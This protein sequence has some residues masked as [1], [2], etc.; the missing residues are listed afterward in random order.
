MEKIN[1]A[2][3]TFFYVGY[4]PVAPG[5]W[6]SFFTGLII[7]FAFK[8]LSI[9]LYLFLL[10][11]FF[12]LGSLG[13][14]SITKRYEVEDPRWIVLD[15]VIG[16]MI[17]LLPLYYNVVFNYKVFVVA[18]FLFRFFDILKPFPVSW[19]DR[20]I[21][22]GWGVMLDDVLAGI[23]SAIILYLVRGYLL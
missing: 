22:N 9:F 20:N 1:R 7:F 2:F 8:H 21:K 6:A 3:L 12:I 10:L 15:E 14:D 13:A 5:T 17:S 23:Y 4:F 18:F 19:A 11:S 16:M